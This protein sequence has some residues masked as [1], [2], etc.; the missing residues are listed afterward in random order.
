MKIVFTLVLVSIIFTGQ[1]QE[2][3]AFWDSNP[4]RGC[5]N[6]NVNPTEQWFV[7]AA[8]FHIE[9]VRLAYDKWGTIGR[10]FL[11]GDASNYQGLVKADLEKLKQ[12]LSWAEKNKIKIVI[13]PLSLP[14]CRWMQNNND[15]PDQRLW[16]DFA[17][18]EQ[19]FTFWNDLATELKDYRCIVAYDIL[20]EPCPELKTGIEEQTIPGDA[21]R[22]TLWYEK[23][24][25]TPRDL[26]RFYTKIIASIRQVDT[27]TPIMVESGFYAQPPAYSGWPGLLDD[28]KIL[29][30]VHMYEPYSFTSFTN[31]K[32]G[33]KFSYPGNI[34]FG[35]QTTDWNRNTLDLY[36]KPFYK[37]AEK[38]KLPVNRI[39]AAEFGCMRRNKGADKYLEDVIDLLEKQKYHWA[40]YSFREDGWDGYDY[41]LGTASLPS[42]YWQAV[43]KG[44]KPK[45]PRNNNP[46]FETIIQW[47]D[48]K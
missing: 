41:E 6:M 19:A 14:G 37:W 36:F 27:T 39:V 16:E 21:K 15:K 42:E 7:D 31:F 8:S 35:N 3:M 45:L 9:W 28:G 34:D 13:A 20:N 38:N 25:N 48:K 40:F 22:F 29:Y 30:S 23:Y 11:I 18:H 1:S 33:G 10:D 5:N 44:E 26:F 32:N 43:E 24:K 17:Y 12:M 47:F 4:R 2:K 46:L